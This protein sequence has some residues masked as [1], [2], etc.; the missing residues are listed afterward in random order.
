MSFGFLGSLI[1]FLG[2]IAAAILSRKENIRLLASGRVTS[3]CI[4][5]L[6]LVLVVFFSSAHKPVPFLIISV[7]FIAIACGNSLFGVLTS[8]ISRKLGQI[9]Y[10]IY[11]LHGI[12]LFIAF[13]FIVGLPKAMVISPITHWVIVCACSI[14]I[15]I[16]C[17]LTYKYIEL[18][19]MKAASGVT[20][21]L[22]NYLRRCEK[23][24]A[25]T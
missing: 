14:F 25:V 24:H 6:L 22:R 16:I 4:L 23:A 11:L 15:V 7:I 18:P 10:G 3:V 19:T 12:I 9:S 20:G 17:S 2:G 5:F 13:R 8:N 21:K 1:P